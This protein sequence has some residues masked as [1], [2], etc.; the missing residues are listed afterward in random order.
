M[1]TATCTASGRPKEGKPKEGKPINKA[2]IKIRQTK[3][4]RKI[5][6]MIKENG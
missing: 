1:S 6:G 3:A 2:A 4:V 5:R